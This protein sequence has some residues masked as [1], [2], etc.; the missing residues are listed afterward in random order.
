MSGATH[1]LEHLMFKGAK[2]YG[3]GEFNKLVEGNGG[4]FNAYTTRDMTVYYENLPIKIKTCTFFNM[5][6]IVEVLL[7]RLHDVVEIIQSGGSI[8]NLLLV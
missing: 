8:V 2:K 1:F 3:P 5:V 7:V 6:R 4:S